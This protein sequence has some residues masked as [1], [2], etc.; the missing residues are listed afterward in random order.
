MTG[1]RCVVCGAGAHRSADACARCKRILE[2]AETRRDASG[3]LRRVNAAARLRALAR[4]WRD[5]AFHCFY[6]GV[7]LT[8]DH[9]RWRDH[10]YLVFEDRIPGDG[11]SVVVTCALL[12]RMKADLTEDR[13]KLIVTEL[14]KVFDGGTF[15]QGAF[16]DQPHAGITRSPPACRLF[17]TA[18]SG[19][20]LDSC[21]QT[22]QFC[23]GPSP[24]GMSSSRQMRAFSPTAAVHEHAA[25]GGGS[26]CA[27]CE[28]GVVLLAP[29]RGHYASPG[30][31]T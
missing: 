31:P 26:W 23:A 30:Y 16:P 20:Q 17:P 13:F 22:L 18:A 3:G 9:S 11:A 28:I 15:D 14:A 25:G 7:C 8:E 19:Q 12:S 2:R 6:T 29:G 10:R 27:W 21:A 4:S 5:G 1:D 24:A